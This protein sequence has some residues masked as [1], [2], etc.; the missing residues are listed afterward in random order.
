MYLAGMVKNNK[1]AEI[2]NE[3]SKW[4]QVAIQGPK[5]VELIK[6]VLGDKHQSTPYFQFATH[7]GKSGNWFVARTGYTGEDGYEVFLPNADAPGFW[8]SLMKQGEDLGVA[9]IGLGARDTLRTEM[10]YSLYGNEITDETS[11]LEAGL[12]WVVKLA[13]PDFIGKSLLEAEKAKGLKRKLVGFK[14]SDKGIPRHG[15]PLISL[16]NSPIGE[17]TSGTMSPSLK[18]AVGVGY[19]ASQ[20]ASEGSSFFVQIRGR[21]LRA[22]VVKTP[23]V[24]TKGE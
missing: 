11:P 2:K 16:D 7:S 17:V 13:K 20:H 23:F 4:A 24:N 12:G 9:P 1:G 10:K 22:T 8:Q 6:R 14:L 3:S 5:A 19:V 15:Y 21:N 18:E